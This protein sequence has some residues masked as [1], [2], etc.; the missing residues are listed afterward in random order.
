MMNRRTY[1]PAVGSASSRHRPRLASNVSAI[2]A[3]SARKAGS[4]VPSCRTALRT[5]GFAYRDT[6][7]LSMD[8]DS[9]T[10]LSNSLSSL[11]PSSDDR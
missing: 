3:Q 11:C 8:E 4:V 6:F 7:R 5:S 2:N 1:R 9:A 10:A